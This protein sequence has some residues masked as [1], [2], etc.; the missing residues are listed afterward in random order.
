MCRYNE[1]SYRTHFVCVACR[2]VSKGFRQYAGLV[3]CPRCGV[4][5]K[6]FGRDFKAPRKDSD[7]QWRKLALMVETDLPLFDSCGCTG[8]GWGKGVLKTLGSAKREVRRRERLT[9]R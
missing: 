3:R 1:H 4:P 2:S 5:M 7:N 9:P 8:P 6:D